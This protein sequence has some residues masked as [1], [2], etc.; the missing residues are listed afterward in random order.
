MNTS[1]L[2]DRLAA[3]D[4]KITKAQAKQ[5]VDAVLEAMRAS[6]VSGEEVNLPGFG[7][8]P[9]WL[10]LIKVLGESLVAFR[11]GP[12]S[13]PKRSLLG[14]AQEQWVADQLKASVKAGK[15][16]QLVAQQIVM[17]GLIL[18]PAATDIPITSA[19]GM[20]S[21]TLPTGLNRLAISRLLPA[22]P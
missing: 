12:W 1:D 7:N 19:S 9:F 8:L 21:R 5:L 18:P 20:P 14:P 10:V 13:D 6:L 3:S 22:L 17:G 2:V 16:W 4:D 15:K 11:D